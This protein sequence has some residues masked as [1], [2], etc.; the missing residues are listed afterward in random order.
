MPGLYEDIRSGKVHARDPL[1]GDALETVVR[2]AQT[3][4]LFDFAR[5]SSDAVVL[6]GQ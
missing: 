5:R 3:P 2:Q 4:A 1:S 6:Q